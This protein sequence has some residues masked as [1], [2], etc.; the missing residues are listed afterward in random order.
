MV[1]EAMASGL[2]CISF[3]YAAGCRLIRHGMNGYLADCD[4]E[5][6]FVAIARACAVD[7]VGLTGAK[8]HETAAAFDW[9][10]ITQTFEHYLHEVVAT[11]AT[12]ART[13]PKAVPAAPGELANRGKLGG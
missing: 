3:N 1:L 4:D 8:A 7:G 9:G 5:A 10:L 6:G 12:S 13:P 11:Q 2:S